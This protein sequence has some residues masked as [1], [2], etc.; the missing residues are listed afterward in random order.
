VSDEANL[1]A[2]LKRINYAGSIAP[3]LETLESVHR[4]HP[5][6]IPFEN[7]DPLMGRP[8]R[9][10]LSDIEQKLLNERRGG[11][12][13]E[14][15]LLFK[16]VLES[17]D[18]KV[19]PLAAR[20]LWGHDDATAGD[21]QLTHMALI[22]DVG[23]VP[24]L[25]DVGFGG[26]V[27]TAPLRLRADIEQQ[28]PN[29]RYRLSG[30]HPKWRLDSE[31]A[32][33]WRPLYEFTLAPQTLEDYIAMNDITMSMFRDELIAARVEGANRY[34]LH[35]AR[36]S[37]H[38]ANNTDTRQLSTIA[39]IREVLTGLFGIQLPDS[40][41]LDPALEKVLRSETTD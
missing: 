39:E 12:C 6:V 4:L 25:A 11:Y 21:A 26:Q 37:T 2:Y 14:H 31:I 23:G 34:A 36:L 17:M 16:A 18:F 30:G 33:D 22:V 8:V 10:Q 29:G 20:V 1:D 24:Y 3:T 27:M 9:L 7:L 28:T 15:N 35:N 19:T 5:A 13:F 41:K 38:E 40:D 32:A